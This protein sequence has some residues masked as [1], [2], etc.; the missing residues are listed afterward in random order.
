[1]NA[2]LSSIEIRLLKGRNST[3]NTNV[4]GL[5]RK[6]L[7]DFCFRKL[8]LR[9]PQELK[10]YLLIQFSPVGFMLSRKRLSEI[11]LEIQKA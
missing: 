5:L 1:M 6:N 2:F 7:N 10:L 11:V 9:F 8:N 4:E 3:Q